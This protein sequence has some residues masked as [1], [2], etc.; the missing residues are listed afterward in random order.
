M[1]QIELHRLLRRQLK[2]SNLSEDQLEKLQPFLIS[3]NNAYKSFD[4]DI[5]HIENVL[6]VNS[7]ELY[8]ANQKLK[9]ENHLKTEE[10]QKAKISL[11]KVIDNVSDIIIEMDANGNF[12]YLNSAWEKFAGE[13]PEVSLGK[14]FMEFSKEIQYF[15]PSLNK[16]IQEKKFSKFKTVFSRFDKHGNLKWWELS[17]KMIKNEKSQIEGAIASLVDITSL[18]ETENKLINANKSKDRFLS[19][20]SHEI[21]TPLNA[22]IAIS[23]LL[24]M[25]DPKPE[26]LNNL[27]NLKYSSKH[28]L[29]LI[30]DILDYNKL[31]SGKLQLDKTPFNLRK[32]LNNVVKSLSYQALEK[33]L[34]LNLE[35]DDKLP[36][37]V[38]GDSHRLSQ[39][40]TNLVNNAIKFTNKGSVDVV[41]TCLNKENSNA[42][43]N[44]CVSDTGIGIHKE[45]LKV[46][47]DRFTQAE[48]NT[49]KIYGGTGLGLAICK[50]IINLHGSKIFVRSEIDKG[51]CF[52][53]ELN[54]QL[55]LK[56]KENIHKIEKPILNLEG[57]NILVVDDNEINLVVVKQF[58]KKWKLQYDE[59]R[60][61]QE[62]IEKIKE[63]KYDLVLLD[64]QM[65]I[66]DGYTTSMELR[67]QTNPYF[68]NLPIIA[69]SASVSANIID[70]VTSAGMNDYLCK[71]F[72]PENLYE[73][74]KEHCLV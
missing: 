44:F 16:K 23:N 70:K 34:Q 68:K 47:F 3:V 43:I 41:V 10:A 65:P 67:K 72:D 26:Q 49:T 60:N 51:S 25:E 38:L 35:F 48:T 61:G 5:R 46:I 11:Q 52:H 1:E 54:Y 45:K 69:L 55:A 8:K 17:T 6:E 28:L 19:T 24:L 73:K 40:I 58:L 57:K 20:M 64:L 29:H 21:R 71:P 63:N 18:K 31:I 13:S 74:I 30:N 22:V 36:N 2:K 33:G 7:S 42:T 50:K 14:N 66:M 62:A 37:H 27:K 4:N 56:E 53:F 39:V 32:E 15:D 12:T 59:A 9:T